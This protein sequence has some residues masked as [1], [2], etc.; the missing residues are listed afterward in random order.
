MSE[1]KKKD[2]LDY[3][4]QII[5]IFNG[6]FN[7]PVLIL[8]LIMTSVLII[9]GSY[10]LIIK[11]ST[12]N[13]ALHTQTALFA[14]PM[15]TPA[16]I[17][18]SLTPFIF[19]PTSTETPPGDAPPPHLV[20]FKASDMSADAWHQVYYSLDRGAEKRWFTIHAE[21][22]DK[23]EYLRFSENIRV[24][25]DIAPGTLLRAQLYVD[26]KLV[27]EGDFDTNGISYTLK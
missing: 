8:G 20:R 11:R 9:G 26:N 13:D 21:D 7:I 22:C 10:D 23:E 6:C 2:P 16:V 27:A 18:A 25:V 12:A 15:T 4:K 1:S 24:W 5:E 17:V 14:T 3:L 19:P